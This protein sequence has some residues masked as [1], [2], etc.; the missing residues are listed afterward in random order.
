MAQ[1]QKFEMKNLIKN[2]NGRNALQTLI[3]NDKNQK[4]YNTKK[5]IQYN[6]KLI[7]KS[8]SINN[9]LYNIQKGYFPNTTKNSI[10]HAKQRNKQ[11]DK[12]FYSY[13]ALY[14]FS[15]TNQ[16]KFNSN[17]KHIKDSASS[18]NLICNCGGNNHA[19]FISGQ[20]DSPSNISIE[21]INKNYK[22][23]LKNINKN[24]HEKNLTTVLY[25]RRGENTNKNL[26]TTYY[27]FN[28]IKNNIND[29]KINS[30]TFRAPNNKKNKVNY[31]VSRDISS[32]TNTLD[33]LNDS[34]TYISKGRYSHIIYRN[35]SCESRFQ[36]QDNNSFN[37]IGYL[38]NDNLF[39]SR[40]KKNI[41]KEKKLSILSFNNSAI[42]SNF[43]FNPL[44]NKNKIK[45][46]VSSHNYEEN[47]SQDKISLNPNKK[48]ILI[49]SGTNHEIKIT[50]EYKNNINKTKVINR[51]NR[52]KNELKLIENIKS[53]RLKIIP[54]KNYSIQIDNKKIENKTLNSKNDINNLINPK[55]NKMKYK[56]IKN[57][58]K[59]EYNK[60]EIQE[61]KNE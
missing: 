38:K 22:N 34:K 14:K 18:N 7:N 23:I 16:I 6:K 58:V 19:L 4:F 32:T 27:S 30:I 39:K 59:D 9:P 35:G 49:N 33:Y 47:K 41:N 8:L 54:F 24:I 36:T 45:N 61:K 17:L 51:K 42:G 28:N 12:S 20:G 37:P 10:S 21:K 56:T 31:N 55:N 15:T 26:D 57:E 50:N 25:K 44:K 2:D 52:N 5:I 46:E 11:I 60:N 40:L 13:N 3:R 53:E 48:Q 1:F 29:Y 43:F